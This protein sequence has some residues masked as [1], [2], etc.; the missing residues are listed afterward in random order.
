MPKGIQGRENHAQSLFLHSYGLTLY[1]VNPAE[2]LHHRANGFYECH[3]SEI[4]FR[5]LLLFLL[6]LR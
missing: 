4:C 1:W 5:T 3:T 6:S 2:Q